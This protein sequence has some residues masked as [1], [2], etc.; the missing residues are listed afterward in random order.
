EKN[1]ALR[2][3]ASSSS[4]TL[5]T[6][7]SAAS[8]VSSSSSSST[9]TSNRYFPLPQPFSEP[10]PTH[11]SRHPGKLALKEVHRLIL[12][13]GTGEQWIPLVRFV[14]PLTPAPLHLQQWAEHK[15]APSPSSSSSSQDKF[16]TGPDTLLME[17]AEPACPPT[18][19]HHEKKVAYKVFLEV[20][21]GST[22]NFIAVPRV[23]DSAQ[24]P[25]SDFQIW[26]EHQSVGPTQQPMFPT[27]AQAA[28]FSLSA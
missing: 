8:S 22:S 18:C 26:P 23:K 20:K 28:L 10:C 2:S 25:R 16:S 15:L 6:S 11:C 1:A 9:S 12:P 14:T 27:S 21:E 24:Y 7:T 3:S 19:S 4:S 13:E 5:A 17:V